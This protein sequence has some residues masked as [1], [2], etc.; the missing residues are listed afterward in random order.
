MECAS[1]LPNFNAFWTHFS[2]FPFSSH[3]MT[4][5]FDKKMILPLKC[6]GSF[7]VEITLCTLNIFVN[8]FEDAQ[9]S[10]KIFHSNSVC[11]IDAIQFLEVV[12][13]RI[14][15]NLIH[16]SCVWVT[17][18]CSALSHKKKLIDLHVVSLNSIIFQTN[19][20]WCASLSPNIVPE[21]PSLFRDEQ[22]KTERNKEKHHKKSRTQ[23]NTQRHTHTHARAPT[24]PH[25]PADAHV[26]G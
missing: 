16:S 23:T 3:V 15:F 17:V 25:T 4:L 20:L 6:S 9:L 7:F 18:I 11:I 8:L 26:D 21:S 19:D 12:I 22:K 2:V 1:I 24:D 13:L 14:P 10:W 5:N